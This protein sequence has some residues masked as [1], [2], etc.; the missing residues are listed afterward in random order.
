MSARTGERGARKGRGK[1]SR[2]R[3]GKPTWR[4]ATLGLVLLLLGAA[5]FQSLVE[6]TANAF[7]V[8]QVAMGGAAI[9]WIARHAR[10]RNTL[11]YLA[12]AEAAIVILTALLVGTMSGT[13]IIQN[14]D[15]SQFHDRYGA[16]APV[17]LNLH[18]DDLFHSLPFVFNLFLLALT[19]VAT[20]IVR[21]RALLKWRHIGRMATHIAVVLVLLGGLVGMIGGEK[22]ML[23]LETGQSASAFPTEVTPDDPLP[24]EID[25]GFTVRLDAFELDRYEPEFRFYTYERKAE[26]DFE[27]IESDPAEPG[28]EV[29]APPK[30]TATRVTVERV[31]RSIAPERS[32]VPDRSAAPDATPRPAVRVDMAEGGDEGSV[33]LAS[34][35]GEPAAYRDTEGRFELV[36]AWQEPSE[37]VLSQLGRGDRPAKHVLST[38]G[39]DR[40]EVEPG[41]THALPDGKELAVGGFYPEFNLD[42]QTG[43]ATTRSNEPNN[44]ALG[45]KIYAEGED[46]ADV[47]TRYLFA[48]GQMAGSDHGGGANLR[49]EYEPG[50]AGAPHAV[51]L[52]ADTGE[53]LDVEG[54]RVV[55]RGDVEWG[56]PLDLTGVADSMT[57]VVHE[58]IRNATPRTEFVDRPD[59][60]VRAAAQVVV[61]RPGQEPRER[62]LLA[63]RNQPI[64]LGEDRLVVYR[65]KPDGIKN[66]KS[67]LTI[68]EDGEPVLT[69]VIR[70]NDPL[71]YA[72][73]DLYQSNFDPDNPKYSGVQV[74]YDPGLPL[75]EFGMWLLVFGVLQAVALARWKPW[76]RRRRSPARSTSSAQP[77]E[78]T[79]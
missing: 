63:E 40:V 34:Q 48:K 50:R 15:A 61:T 4:Q 3:R 62:L 17:L 14:V 43:K 44:P 73:V 25:L 58:P 30:D 23:H 59:G 18:A 28:T 1:A 5:G 16:L 71:R 31:F 42:I 20:I 75:V 33:W 24:R 19:S 56:E 11:R 60:P 69:E 76:W 22:G 72:G 9:L 10:W 45:V 21:R 46:P 13:L 70:V 41:E 26:G 53:R 47:K 64:R 55:G 79:A 32:F 66:Y 52:V 8:V 38:P 65:E 6:G 54:G 74:V 51:V 12:S 2:R 37:D 35:S 39:G 29:G 77:E 49:Y 27:L 68:L 7:T 36:L 57:A 67:T 78:V